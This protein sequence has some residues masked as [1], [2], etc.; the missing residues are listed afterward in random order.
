MAEIIAST[1]EVIRKIGSGGGGTVYLANHLRLHKQVVVKAYKGQLSGQPEML[2][3]EVDVLKDLNHPRIP[4]VYDFFVENNTVYTVMDYIQGESLD[5][6]LDRGERFSQAQVVEWAI[7]L[8]DALA[9]LHSPTHGD[10]P[11]G[12]VH[13][14]IK[15]ANLMR[16]PDNSICLID[17]NIA[18]ALGETSIVGRSAGYAP[19]E[20]YGMIYTE[21]ETP[22][23]TLSPTVRLSQRLP[24]PGRG[25]RRTGSVSYSRTSHEVELMLI[26][27]DIRSDIYSV[28]ATL[29]HLIS[30]ICPAEN[31]E[32]VVPLSGPA[33]SPQVA[34]IINRAMRLDPNL[35]YQSAEEMLADFLALRAN[36]PRVRRRRVL[37]GVACAAFAVSF[38]LGIGAAFTGLKRMQTTENWLHLA[39]LSTNALQAGDTRTAIQDALQA[40]PQSRNLFTPDWL[41]QPQR[42]L[43]NALGVYQLADSYQSHGS[44]VLP[45]APLFVRL[46][47]GGTTAAVICS[48]QLVVVDTDTARIVAQ[49]PASDSALA[50]VEYLDETHLVFA[51]ADGVQCCEIPSGTVLWT[52]D[53]GTALAVS[54]DGSTVAAIDRDAGQ[55]IIL[56]AASG[57]SRST[58]S[59]DGHAQQVVPNDLFANP[60]DSLL[61]LNEDGSRMAVSFSDGSLYLYN[62]ETGQGTEILS[63]GEF[64]HFEGGFSGQ[65]LA[66]GASGSERSVFAVLD[67]VTGQQTGGFQSDYSFGVLVDENGIALQN[68][69]LLVRIDPVSG[70]QTP[71]VTTAQSIR[72]FDA[73]KDRALIALEDGFE[74]YDSTASRMTRFDQQAVDFVQL[75]GD[76]A[77]VADRNTASLRLLRYESHD[78]AALFNYDPALSHDEARLS[79]DGQRVM[80]FDYTGFTLFDRSGNLLTTV[81]LPDAM[82]IYDQ[83]FVREGDTS[84]LEVIYN[85]GTVRRYS[86][87]DGALLE[88]ISGTPPDPT[89]YEEFETEHYRVTSP[90]HESPTLYDRRTGRKI[91][92]LA[93]DAYLTYVTETSAGLVVQFVTTDGEQYGQLLDENGEVLADLPCL[94]D[95]WDDVLI[96]DYPTGNMRISRIF[97]IEELIELAKNQTERNEG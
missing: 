84:C 24:L 43:T 57:T 56:D 30:G 44:V 10:P 96:F 68:E 31:A 90:L 80:L 41:A 69:N 23:P 95:I 14:D 13:S 38:C 85:D 42:A 11:R 97:Q 33:Y 5:R 64:T 16:L 21:T 59:F 17:F 48:G 12:Y 22:Q 66:F 19:P 63:G 87:Q 86:A 76:I 83:Q 20:Y 65:Y 67:T 70:E 18:L 88:E 77:L 2:R 75:A 53:A 82:E 8:L 35:R 72:A 47:P 93:E 6:A 50:E 91:A 94:C 45:S 92:T 40:L 37:C 52:A 28:G 1:Y 15:P 81:D 74:F 71:L 39:E 27:P 29:Y 79:A 49:L 73:E 32:T 9:Y 7:Q 62:L 46:S 54:S 25:R 3:R 34:A 26:R 89:L 78:E 36:D 51:G 4:R 58:V 60:N 61:A 55:A